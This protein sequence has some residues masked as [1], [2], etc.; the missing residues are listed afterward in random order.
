MVLYKMNIYKGG[1][2]THEN[3]IQVFK[4]YRTRI[5]NAKRIPD[6]ERFSV[7]GYRL[8][9]AFREPSYLF[10]YNDGTVVLSINDYKLYPQENSIT[11]KGSFILGDTL[12]EDPADLS[13]GVTVAFMRT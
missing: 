8:T 9:K 10:S 1:E 7:M 5:N 2:L 3:L 4:E 13:D 11:Y 12:P 6:T